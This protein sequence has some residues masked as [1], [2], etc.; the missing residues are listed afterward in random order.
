MDE[1]E[2][3]SAYTV[4][5][6]V[7]V[8]VCDLPLRRTRAVMTK[9]IGGLEGVSHHLPHHYEIQFVMAQLSKGGSK[10][11][12]VLSGEEAATL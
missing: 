7:E 5:L 2:G 8:C 4:A 6:V 3:V 1:E 10:A 12:I 9:D 11:P